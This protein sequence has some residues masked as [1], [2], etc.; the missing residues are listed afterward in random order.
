ME[1]LLDALTSLVIIVS[2]IISV[3][4]ISYLAEKWL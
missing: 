1:D 2:A 4:A 3:L